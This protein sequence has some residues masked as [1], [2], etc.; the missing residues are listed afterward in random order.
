MAVEN[1]GVGAHALHGPGRIDG[2]VAAPDDRHPRTLLHLLL[3]G[4]RFQERQGGIDALQLRAG[5]IEPRFL[6]RSN[7][8]ED[9]I[10][11]ACQLVQGKIEPHPDVELHLHADSL[12]QV[13]LA[14]QDR[15]RQA[16]LRNSET[17]HSARFAPLFKDGDV[18]AQH[19]Q[20]EGRGQPRG[21]GPGY[22]NLVA[23]RRKPAR[24]NPLEH[25]L[26]A[27]GLINRVGEVT[28]HLAHVHYLIE[29]LAAAAVVA[30]MLADPSR[31]CG[32]RIVQD[33][34]FEGVLQPALLVKLQETRN[35]HP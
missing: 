14:P 26:K 4:P 27:F 12:D 17:Q 24:H 29:G 32:Q 2:R 33:H 7:G 28:M 18:V 9:R 8:Q 6:P 16:V 20:I 1:G 31:G 19:G 23:R 11:A 34:G 25:R 5:Q 15:F 3:L 35:V 30:G 22:G 13:Q 10:V 21:T